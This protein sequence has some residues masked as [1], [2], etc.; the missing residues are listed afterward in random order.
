MAVLR[1]WLVFNGAQFAYKGRKAE[2]FH[3]AANDASFTLVGMLGYCY[4]M[5]LGRNRCLN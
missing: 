4:I 5:A 2:S 1:A 3:I